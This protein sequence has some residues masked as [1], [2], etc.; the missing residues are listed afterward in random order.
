MRAS[1]HRKGSEHGDPREVRPEKAA[2]IAP[3]IW[4]ALLRGPKAL[5]V[6]FDS[7]ND[8]CENQDSDEYIVRVRVTRSLYK[9][10]KP[11]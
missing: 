4:W 8:A 9:H 5:P 11:R 7:Y 1:P 3:G 6:L 2:G 10:R